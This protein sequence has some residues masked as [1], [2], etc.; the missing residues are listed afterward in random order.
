VVHLHLVVDADGND[1]AGRD[2]LEVHL[3]ARHYHAEGFLA[4]LVKG[5]A[6][7]L[8][9]VPTQ[10]AKTTRHG[11]PVLQLALLNLLARLEGGDLHLFQ[12]LLRGV[13]GHL[14]GLCL[15]RRVPK[16]YLQA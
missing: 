6:H 10:S 4:P 15:S 8:S 12:L 5:A 16:S 2:R 1:V 3:V 11:T 9:D 13:V 7:A 14:D